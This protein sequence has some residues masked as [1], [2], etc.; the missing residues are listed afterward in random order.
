M[1]QSACCNVPIITNCFHDTWWSGQHATMNL[2]AA[3]CPKE[4]G[5]CLASRNTEKQRSTSTNA[6]NAVA[7]AG[8]KNAPGN[9]TAVRSPAGVP[10]TAHARATID[11]Q[12]GNHSRLFL[13]FT[14]IYLFG[15]LFFI[16][17][18]VSRPE[19]ETACIHKVLHSW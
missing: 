12:G 7:R 10:A 16:K 18:R 15:E 11:T 6:R 5:L 13:S 9:Q 3:M 14:S 17:H 2:S 4:A 19:R 8:I 1:H